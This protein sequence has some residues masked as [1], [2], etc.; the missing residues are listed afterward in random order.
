[1]SVSPVEPNIKA[2]SKL[3]QLTEEALGDL[4]GVGHQVALLLPDLAVRAFVFPSDVKAS[5][6]G[7]MA[8]I[9][10]RL[11]YPQVE[12][13]IDTWKAPTGWILAVAIRSVVLRQYEQALEALGCHVVWVDGASLVPIP[14][15]TKDAQER[16]AKPSRDLPGVDVYVQLYPDHYT[17]VVM[18]MAEVL[19][20]RTKLRD[21]ADD[22]RIAEHILRLP[23]LFEEE[24]CEGIF[25]QGWGAVALADRL[26]ATGVPREKM[27]LGALGEEEHL[28]SLLEILLK[29]I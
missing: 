26:E 9:A 3:A 14:R 19:D 12:A 1:M 11:S 7:L 20:V 10:P 25:L 23:S 24:H 15:W 13:H 28:A 27:S 22:S 21:S 16:G 29:R 4:G 8:G 2:V 18:R 17:L 5:P 6:G